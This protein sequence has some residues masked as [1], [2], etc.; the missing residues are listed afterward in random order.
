MRSSKKPVSRGKKPSRSTLASRRT[1]A[2]KRKASSGS[3]HAPRAMA[4][5]SSGKSSMANRL[6]SPRQRER[7]IRLLEAQL[8]R[9]KAQRPPSHHKQAGRLTPAQLRRAKERQQQA[10]ARAVSHA[11]PSVKLSRR[12]L[13]ARA[14][15][16]P[17][18]RLGRWVKIR[19]PRRHGPL[20]L[21]KPATQSRRAKERRRRARARAMAQPRDRLGRWVKVQVSRRQRPPPQPRALAPIPPSRWLVKVPVVL[22]T[23]TEDQLDYA[24]Y[25]L[26]LVIDFNPMKE[27]E[28]FA[29]LLQLYRFELQ[30]QDPHVRWLGDK[31]R[32]A[33][34]T[35]PVQ[36]WT[37][38][39]PPEPPTWWRSP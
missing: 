1:V 19:A 7:R 35:L 21:S 31:W 29:E 16:Q 3:S 14:K 20:R 22:D 25:N 6:L 28:R 17:R 15:A 9:L 27:P 23:S 11:R 10:R 33:P 34:T 2:S 13:S 24:D 36:A 37:E 8:E 39:E 5:R 12:R 30:S 18:D 38:D 26:W 32:A 4:R